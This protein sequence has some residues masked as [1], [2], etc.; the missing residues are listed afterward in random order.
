MPGGLGCGMLPAGLKGL[1]A[2][3]GGTGFVVCRGGVAGAL[4]K[5]TVPT[6]RLSPAQASAASAG[7]RVVTAIRRPVLAPG[8]LAPG[9]FVGLGT[10]PR[11]H[12]IRSRS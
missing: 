8:W 7:D 2:T 6:G 9:L 3:A 1:E 12:S 11:D 10:C 4:A 5:R